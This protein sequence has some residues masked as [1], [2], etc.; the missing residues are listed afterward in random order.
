MTKPQDLESAPPR[1]APSVDVILGI[2]QEAAR[3]G[4]EVARPPSLEDIGVIADEHA[5]ALG[6]QRF[7]GV[8]GDRLDDRA[9]DS[10]GYNASTTI[11]MPMPPPMHN[12]AT[13]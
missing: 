8:G 11:A 3:R 6:R 4:V 7:P 10:N 2:D 5:A 13:P 12:D 1:L 9:H